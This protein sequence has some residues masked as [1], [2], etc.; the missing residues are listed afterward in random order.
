[1]AAQWHQNYLQLYGIS[2]MIMWIQLL[3]YLNV[4]PGLAMPINAISEAG[5]EVV[6]F[7]M[8]ICCIVISMSLALFIW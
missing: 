4:V 1:M 2:L 3:R 5:V 6:A 8:A 7:F